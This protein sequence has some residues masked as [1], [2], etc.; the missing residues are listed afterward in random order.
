MCKT[1]NY[2]NSFVATD[3]LGSSLNV[4]DAVANTLSS[5]S[6]ILPINLPVTTAISCATVV[7]ISGYFESFLKD[8]VSEYIAKLNAL[9]KPLASIPYEM[10][11]KNFTGGSEALTLAA[12]LDKKQ[13]STSKS[14]DLVRRLAS[15]SN[16]TSYELVWE[17]FADTKSNPGPDI[18]KNILKGVDAEH[19]WE[20]INKLVTK[21]GDLNLFLTAFIEIRNACAHT[22]RHSN[23]PTGQMLAE[24]VEKFKLLSE[25]IDV[26]LGI[27]LE[28]FYKAIP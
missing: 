12:K 10:R 25:C 27:R 6:A 23:P 5:P 24:Y 13:K 18:V 9:N 16:P 1:Y 2:G 15:I 4:V 21:H 14:D 3:E 20:E 11:M 8:I 26:L 7:L 22:G 19:S 17:A 28:T